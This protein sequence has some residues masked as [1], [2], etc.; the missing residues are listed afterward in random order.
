MSYVLLLA[1]T[2]TEA[3]ENALSYGKLPAEIT[4]LKDLQGFS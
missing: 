1:M 2:K 3:S 4:L